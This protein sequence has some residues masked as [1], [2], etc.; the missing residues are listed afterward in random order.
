MQL[1]NSEGSCWTSEFGSA[2][3]NQAERFKAKSGIRVFSAPRRLRDWC[4]R[5]DV[6]FEARKHL[7]TDAGQV[8]PGF[9]IDGDGVEI[10]VHSPFA[11]RQD[12]CTVEDRNNDALVM[13]ATFK[14]GGREIKAVAMDAVFDNGGTVVFDPLLPG[15]SHSVGTMYLGNGNNLR[16]GIE[17]ILRYSDLATAETDPV[18]ITD[19]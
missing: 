1:V 18:D 7:V 8:V 12:E 10:F 14:V 16:G 4:E 17:M 13:H 11:M 19:R 9:T 6:D 3:R 5:N 2:T 15:D